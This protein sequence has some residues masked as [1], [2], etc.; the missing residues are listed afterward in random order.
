MDDNHRLYQGCSATQI[1]S[2]VMGSAHLAT[3]P[4]SSATLDPVI[5][6]EAKRSGGTC[7]FTFG[8][9][10]TVPE[11]ITPEFRFCTNANRRSLHYATLRSG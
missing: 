9:S 2:I 5:P 4:K 6:T 10:E 3:I 7:G 8:H 1:C 11:R